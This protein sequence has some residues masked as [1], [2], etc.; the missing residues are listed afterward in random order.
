M[1]QGD[2]E[3]S[4]LDELD[5]SVERRPESMARV[6]THAVG[7]AG[8]AESW[9]ARKRRAKRTWGRSLRV[10]AILLGGL[11][12]VLP[13]V[14]E[15]STKGHTSSIAPG[16]A[17]VA[18]AAAA[19]LVALDR[20]FGFS[21]AW[22]RFMEAEL[23]ITRL[24]HNFEYVWNAARAKMTDPL[25]D[26]DVA[27]LLAKA[28]EFVIAVDDVVARET[29]AWIAEFRTSLERAEADLGHSRQASQSD[30]R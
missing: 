28:R 25:S 17:T 2:L 22:M 15:I 3:R 7:L 29:S 19:T 18:L 12:A 13:I 21:T 1:P 4:D 23:H 24:R 26:E 30:G 5:W 27:A 6:F 16:W 10:A 11:A 8:S 9:Y 20:Y 14:A